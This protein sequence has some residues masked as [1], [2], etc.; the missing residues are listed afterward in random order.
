MKTQKHPH[1]KV[2]ISRNLQNT[3]RDGAKKHDLSTANYA[4]WLVDYALKSLPSDA[5]PIESPND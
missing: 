2:R 5:L 4:R 3:L 1:V